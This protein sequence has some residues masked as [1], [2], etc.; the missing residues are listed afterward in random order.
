MANNIIF[1][2]TAGDSIIYGKQFRAS[3]G[4]V[5]KTDNNQLHIDPGPGTLVRAMQ[6]KINVRETTGILVSNYSILRSND[7]NALISG[8][9]Y[10]GLDHKGVIAAYTSIIKG[11][12][13]LRPLIRNE[14]FNYVEKAIALETGK[15]V[16]INN[17][18]IHATKTF[19]AD[20]IGFKI[21]T[22]DFVLGYTSD[23]EFRAEL[24]EEFEDVNILIVNCKNPEGIKEKG[25]MNT[26]DVI[27]LLEKI[28]PELTVITGFG[29]KMIE[30]DPINE[31]R[32]I[33]KA[34][35]C[36]VMAAKDGLIINPTSYSAKNK[37]SR[38]KSYIQ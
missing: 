6:T 29:V 13:S 37:Q 24:A 2:G 31:A 27:K 16:G 30:H 22:L 19:N 11:S 28:K 12:E 3:G 35:G 17:A 38:L 20:S 1:L 10:S 8:M 26:A 34:T 18:E 4:I 25:S 7:L 21:I 5:I 14:C 23:T 36:Q 9:T 33:Q 15:K 32:K